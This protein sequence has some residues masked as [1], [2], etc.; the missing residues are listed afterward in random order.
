ML[1]VKEQVQA[2]ALPKVYGIFQGEPFNQCLR[3]EKAL[4]NPIQL[5][6]SLFCEGELTILF[7]PTNSGKSLFAVQLAEIAVTA[8]L[9]A[10]EA[11]RVVLYFD[12]EMSGKQQ[13]LRFTNPDSGS[14][15][16]FPQ[17]LMR[18]N[19]CLEW[20]EK[21]TEQAVLDGLVDSVKATGAKV[22]IFDNITYL[23]H[24]TQESDEAIVLMQELKRVVEDLKITMLCVSHTPK[25]DKSRPIE[26]SDLIGSSNVSSFADAVFA[27][28]RSRKGRNIR[29]VKQLKARCSSIEYGDDNVLEYEIKRADD[30][31]LYFAEMGTSLED[32]HLTDSTK[33][34]EKQLQRKLIQAEYKNGMDIPTIVKTYGVS[35]YVVKSAIK[36]I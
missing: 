34:T 14:L 12:L 1:S 13:Q 4:P 27:V 26:L 2:T 22:V 17:E 6:K 29:Y 32:D 24:R 7:G 31:M 36:A 11:P 10:G 28:N 18:F 23:N 25:R 15:H 8:G 21:R 30:G 3:R 35:E 16:P 19:F 33:Q 9:K 20:T 5:Y